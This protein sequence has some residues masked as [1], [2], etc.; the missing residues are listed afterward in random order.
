M[1]RQSPSRGIDNPIRLQPA[2]PIGR[3]TYL[4]SVQQHAA[5]EGTDLTT[6]FS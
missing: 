3:V 2:I 4:L 6:F 1:Q 5:I